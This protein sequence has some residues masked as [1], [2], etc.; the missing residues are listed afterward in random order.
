MIT[1]DA[2][3][4]SKRRLNRAIEASEGCLGGKLVH[5]YHKYF[6]ES[7]DGLNRQIDQQTL[8][9]LIC[10]KMAKARF[11]PQEIAETLQ[12]ASPEA[13][14]RQVAGDTQYSQNLVKSVFENPA[15]QKEIS[16]SK[17]H[18]MDFSR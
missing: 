14:L 9:T 15:I 5:T 4:E 12:K 10:I 2:D 8:D 16:K 3:R 7:L 18:S 13:P 17:S 6:K 11:K 1:N